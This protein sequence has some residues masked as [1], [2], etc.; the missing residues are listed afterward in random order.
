MH[1]AQARSRSAPRLAELFDPGSDGAAWWGP[2]DVAAVWRHQLEATVSVDLA[3]LAP[4]VRDRLRA[5]AESDG[6]LLKSYRDLL[7]HPC[8]PT[9][10]LRLVKEYAKLC[11]LSRDGPLP[12]EAAQALY[13]LSIAA[14]L[15]RR[16]ERISSLSDEALLDGL[17]W[18]EAQPWLDEVLRMLL[19]EARS[20]LGQGGRA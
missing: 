3:A 11:R 13:Y 5:L 10:L 6:L 19:H 20:I 7:T 9:S 12:P 4:A 15:T 14:A 8:P 17:A 1:D 16:G 2:E 18:A